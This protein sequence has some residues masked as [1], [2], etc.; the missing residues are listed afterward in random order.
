M[1]KFNKETKNVG[2]AVPMC[3]TEYNRR[4]PTES[5]ITTTDSNSNGFAIHIPNQ[6]KNKKNVFWVDVEV[7]KNKYSPYKYMD[8][9]D[10]YRWMVMGHRVSRYGWGHSSLQVFH[11]QGSNHF[12]TIQGFGFGEYVGEPTFANLL[13]QVSSR[14]KLV[15]WIP[16]YVDVMSCDWYLT[17]FNEEKTSNPFGDIVTPFPCGISTNISGTLTPMNYLEYCSVNH[18]PLMEFQ[19]NVGGY[20]LHYIEHDMHKWISGKNLKSDYSKIVGMTIGDAMQALQVGKTVGRIG[21]GCTDHLL[22][23]DAGK[24]TVSGYEFDT[25]LS[26]AKFTEA[27]FIHTSDNFLQPWNPSNE[28]VFARDWYVLTSS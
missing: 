25:K 10:A 7:A 26:H 14:N 27:I 23:I 8:W 11:M 2:L 4:F 16:T 3:I 19:D 21:W 24:H 5:E 17:G 1:L 9:A 13:F 15:P 6:E 12:A 28:D 22:F 20:D 18:E